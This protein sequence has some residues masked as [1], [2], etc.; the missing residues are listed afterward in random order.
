[1]NVYGQR[2]MLNGAIMALSVAA[3]GFGLLWLVLV[4]WTLLWNGFTAI[5]P[6]LFAEMT[7]PPGS[8]GGLLNAIFGSVVMTFI[9]TLI[10]T[11]TGIL[12]GT[13]LAEYSRGS[14]FGEVV[15][16]I[17][18]ILLSAP[19]I[20]VG[21]FVYEMMVVRMGHFSAW[22]GAVALAIIVIP[23]VVRTTEDMLNLVPNTLREAAAALG[24][25]KWKVIVMVAYRAAIQGI[26][27]GIMLA[28]ARI[29]GET[30]PLLFT[31]LNNQFWSTNLNA[32]MANL[33]VVIFQFAMSPYADWQV[34]AWGGA[35]LITITV[36]F[37]NI[38]ARAL[39][40]WG[41]FKQ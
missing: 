13:F 30:A 36:L 27:T 18:D 21:L 24:S 39:A 9:A 23:V 11:P 31:A 29:A 37:L 20:I 6:I 12:A 41:T 14:R 32:P 40:S 33:P 8:T 1:M 15:R 7:P 19:S 3:T 16:F 17:N 5:S 22:A 35:L 25:P 28:V 4:L 2:R 38:A 26:V 34:L 10:G